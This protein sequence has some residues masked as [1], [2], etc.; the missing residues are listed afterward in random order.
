MW[1]PLFLRLLEP[2]M[3]WDTCTVQGI[4]IPSLRGLWSRSQR[5]HFPLEEATEADELKMC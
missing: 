5:A 4:P 3:T 2:E 1:I